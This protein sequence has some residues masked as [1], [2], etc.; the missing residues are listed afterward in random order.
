MIELIRPWKR[1][2]IAAFD[3]DCVE[4]EPVFSQHDLEIFTTHP[5]T[6]HIARTLYLEYFGVGVL[7]TEY[8]KR[9]MKLC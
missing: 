4:G 8:L 3:R 6:R 5:L 9:P 1:A 7:P 2:D